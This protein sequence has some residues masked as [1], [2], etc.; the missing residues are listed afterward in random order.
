VTGLVEGVCNESITVIIPAHNRASLLDVT[1]RSVLESRLIRSPQQVIVVDDDSLDETGDVARQHG[2]RYV[3]VDFHNISRSRN[4]GLALARSPYVTFLDHDDTWLPGNMEAQLAALEG[5][6][7]A[8]FAY[9]MVRCATEELVPL[10]WTFPSPPLVSGFAPDRFHL[11]YPNLGVVLF[12]RAAVDRVGGFDPRIAYH[13]DGDLMIRVAA[14]YAIVGVEVVGMLHRLRSASKARAD[15][16]WKHRD[17][18]NWSPKDVGV[19]WRTAARLRFKIRG[20][21]FYR[22]CEDALACL[23]VGRRRDA[24]ECLIRAV[25]VSPERA[26]RHVP[27]LG[28]IVGQCV[29]PPRVMYVAQ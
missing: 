23:E 15:Y 16:Y 14:R 1:L 7:A 3:R 27:T 26:V 10:P 2:V 21:F 5:T 8:G 4:A 20:T 11:G 6:P 28:S 18:V 19:G 17:V 22:F 9:G 25:F 29:R 13:Q 24:L 12:R